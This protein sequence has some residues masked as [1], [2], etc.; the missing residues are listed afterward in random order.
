[1]LTS[2][3]SRDLHPAYARTVYAG[4]SMT[5]TWEEVD[6]NG[7]FLAWNVMLS[8]VGPPVKLT[9]GRQSRF[10]P[11]GRQVV[12]TYQDNVYTIPTD[13]GAPVQLT[14]SNSDW[15][16]DWGPDGRIVFQR[17][18]GGN[19]EDIMV[20][21]SDGTGVEPLVSTRNNE[22]CPSWSPDGKRVA[23]YAL[24]VGNYDIYV[25]VMP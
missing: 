8:G 10:S 15:Y 23:Y 2:N 1:M 21:N 5:Y 22:Y 9:E 4:Y 16:P 6:G 11:N 7:H 17:S 3:V 24:V 19:F 18:N 20:M 25:Y 13:G 12:Y 14:S